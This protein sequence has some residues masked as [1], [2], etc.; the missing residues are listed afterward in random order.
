MKWKRTE[1]QPGKTKMVEEGDAM[2]TTI[3]HQHMEC[4]R[5]LENEAA[6]IEQIGALLS[7][8]IAKGR[9]ILICGNG[10][11]AADAQ[12]FAAELVG[13]FERERCAWPAIALTTDT[14]ILTAIGND[15]GFAEVFA[16]QIRGLGQKEDV[17][18]G[19]STSGNSENVIRAVTAAREVGM[20]TI[21]LLGHDGGALQSQTDQAIVVRGAGTARIQEAHILIL[22][23]WA[24]LIEV[25]MNP[26]A[27]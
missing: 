24:M 18:I 14:S 22:H 26:I 15:Y 19:I 10:G 11:S 4:L 6:A 13:R 17:L 21:G 3:L 16:R 1:P 23:Y 8:A 25:Q 9:K 5:T 12:H 20:Q 2:F 7:A 27:Q